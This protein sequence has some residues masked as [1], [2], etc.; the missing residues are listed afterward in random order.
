MKIAFKIKILFYAIS[1]LYVSDCLSQ[2]LGYIAVSVG[3]GVPLKN[4]GSTDIADS[5]AGFAKT[6][7][8]LEISAAYKISKT[9]GI[10]ALV[11]NQSNAMDVDAA[12]KQFAKKYPT[13]KW[14]MQ[15]EN[16]NIKSFMAGIYGSFPIGDSSISFDLKGMLGLSSSTLPSTI[17][18]GSQNGNSLTATQSSATSGA[19][20]FAVGLGFKKYLTDALCLIVG[21]DYMATKPNFSNVTIS[22]SNGTQQTLNG[23]QSI[24][25]FTINAGIGFRL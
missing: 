3:A 23:S 18:T 17:L 5:A 25:L 2:D 22:F 7:L 8:C 11:R 6:G 20:C 13:I 19:L 14:N 12:V 15:A 10:C 16:W 24:T 1:I 9:F 21:V 4:Y